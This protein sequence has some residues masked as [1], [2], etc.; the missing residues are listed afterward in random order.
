[1]IGVLPFAVEMVV[2]LRGAKALDP[3]LRCRPAAGGTRLDPTMHGGQHLF[4]SGKDGECL[5][6]KMSYC[7][8]NQR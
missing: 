3:G 5:L 1:M 6:N 4:K 2:V 7:S 8:S